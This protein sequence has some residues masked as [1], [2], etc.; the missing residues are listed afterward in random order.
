[1]S[2]CF[3]SQAS[4]STLGQLLLFQIPSQLPRPDR[5]LLE[6]LREKES[7]KLTPARELVAKLSPTISLHH[8]ETQPTGGGLSESDGWGSHSYVWLGC[9]PPSGI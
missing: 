9:E 6:L 5:L 7:S 1:M 8:G 3:G 2:T 4:I